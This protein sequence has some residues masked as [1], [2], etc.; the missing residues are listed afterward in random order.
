MYKLI[1]CKLSEEIG[2]KV[3]SMV[4]NKTNVMSHKNIK[5]IGKYAMRQLSFPEVNDPVIKWFPQIVKIN[6][7]NT[8][9]LSQPDGWF[10]LAEPGKPPI[11]A[12]ATFNKAFN[13]A[14]YGY[15]YAE[16]EIRGKGF[17]SELW[18]EVEQHSIAN[19][20]HCIS[21]HCFGGLIPLYENKGYEQTQVDT[22]NRARLSEPYKP[23]IANTVETQEL[24]NPAIEKIM[25]FDRK[26]MNGLNRKDF[27]LSLFSTP[28]SNLLLATKDDHVCGYTVTLDLYNELYEDCHY[29]RHISPWYAETPE[30]AQ[31]LIDATLSIES[32]IDDAQP[33]RSFCLDLDCSNPS[34][35]EVLAKVGVFKEQGKLARMVK[36]VGEGEFR[37]K[38]VNFYNNTMNF[39]FCDLGTGP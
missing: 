23:E 25:A 39:G 27:L 2:K 11:A 5:T 33:R 13:T 3:S 36:L 22:L 6:N 20:S 26:V 24:S 8:T 29:H 9:Y 12:L 10:G 15:Y 14:W 28:N 32:I 31:R 4:A 18:Q 1:L 21:F 35:T 30:I 17:A 16:P 7:Q 37:D 19:G 34:S 38:P